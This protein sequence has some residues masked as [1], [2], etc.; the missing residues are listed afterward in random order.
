[1]RA[2]DSRKGRR[3]PP[4]GSSPAQERTN[5]TLHKD[6][7]SWTYGKGDHAAISRMSRAGRQFSG[8]QFSCTQVVLPDKTKPT[9]LTTVTWGTTMIF[10]M[11]TCPPIIYPPGHHS[12]AI[13]TGLCPQ[14]Q[15]SCTHHSYY[16]LPKR[17]T[18]NLTP[19]GGYREN[20]SL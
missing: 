13:N 1:M 3:L 7:G 6:K 18:L 10:L 17:Q 19:E 4:Q 15:V 9:P 20:P 16:T 14:E 5:S 2:K 11:A 8:R 12:S